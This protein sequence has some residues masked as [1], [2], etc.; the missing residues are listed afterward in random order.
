MVDKIK[1]LNIPATIVPYT[2]DDVYATHD[3]KFGK[4][5]WHSVGTVAEMNA[6]P[7]ARRTI[8]MIVYVSETHETF[9]LNGT[10]SN[11]G[12]TLFSDQV[13]KHFSYT[14]HLYSESDHWEIH[15]GLNKRPAIFVFDEYGREV[16]GGITIVDNNNITID[17]NNPIRG[18]AELN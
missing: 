8:G 10:L 11:A 14:D 6:I 1:G 17:F 18:T 13:D 16:E 12:W 15:H 4:G 9:I 3:S 5:G 2:E 7:E